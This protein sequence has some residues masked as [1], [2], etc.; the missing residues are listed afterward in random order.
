MKGDRPSKGARLYKQER[1]RCEWLQASTEITLV[2]LPTFH[3]EKLMVEAAIGE[4]SEELLGHVVA[5]DDSISGEVVRAGGAVVISDAQ[6]YAHSPALRSI[7]SV[8]GVGPLMVVPLLGD[9]GP[10]VPP[11][12]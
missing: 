11:R 6:Q 9:D 1:R 7:F 4:G 5:A 12:S 10:T 8:E 3:D 2:V